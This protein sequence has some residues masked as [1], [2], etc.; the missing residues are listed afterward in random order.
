MAEETTVAD[1]LAEALAPVLGVDRLPVRLQAWDGTVA[2]PDDAPLVI[3]RSPQAI[4][5]LVWAPDEVGLARAY[6]AGELD[7]EGDLYGAFPALSATGRLAPGESPPLSM[8]VPAVAPGAPAWRWASSDASRHRPRRR[9]ACAGTAGAQPPPR[10]RRHLAPLRHRQRLLRAGPG[11][12]D[13]L[14]L[15]RLGGRTSAWT[16]PRRPSSTWSAASSGCGPGVRLLDVGCG[17]GSLAIHA[18]R[19]Y[20][21]DRRRHH[22]RP[23]SRRGSRASGSP[24]RG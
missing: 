24:R 6:V 20:G 23:R 1:R 2:G 12:V 19:Q 5:R 9:S 4:R 18:A 8:G 22:A 14:L 21:V 16:P 3:I 15:R 11:A 13:G 17:W 7:A 10:R